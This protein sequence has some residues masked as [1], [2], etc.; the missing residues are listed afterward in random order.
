MTSGMRIAYLVAHLAAIALGILA[1]IDLVR[2]V[3]G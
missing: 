1:A 3:G 2:W